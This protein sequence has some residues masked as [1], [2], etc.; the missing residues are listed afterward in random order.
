[1]ITL[2]KYIVGI[3]L[4]LTLNLINIYE[5]LDRNNK[6]TEIS[7]TQGKL[8]F[9]IKLKLNNYCQQLI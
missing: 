3:I 1:M 9:E 2:A 8:V 4:A 7:T 5:S 6:P